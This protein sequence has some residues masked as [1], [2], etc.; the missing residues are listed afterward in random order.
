M[1]SFSFSYFLEVWPKLLEAV[2]YTF[3]F[4]LMSTLVSFAAGILVAMVRIPRIPVLYELTELWMSLIRSMPFVLLL[5]L[6]YFL[7]PYLLQS[8]GIVGSD[9]PKGVYV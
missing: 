4:I 9:V 1:L 3:Y 7:I 8:F 2:P 6:S 5:F